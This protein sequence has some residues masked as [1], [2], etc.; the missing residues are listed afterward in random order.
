MSDGDFG[1]LE[2]VADA[3]RSAS[4]KTPGVVLGALLPDVEMVCGIE[5]H[6]FT[7]GV[8]MLLEKIDHPELRGGVTGIA[9][10]ANALFVF[11]E[12]KKA[13]ESLARGREVFDAEAFDFCLGK[14]PASALPAVGEAIRRQIERGMS[15]VPGKFAPEVEGNDPLAV[16]LRPMQG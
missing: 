15:T 8:L 4:G 16:S 1:R 2:E 3:A 10:S 14:V 7:L 13:R 11:A 9:D 5:I 6:S 12:P